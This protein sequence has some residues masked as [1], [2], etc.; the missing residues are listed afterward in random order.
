MGAPKGNKYA[1]GNEGGRPP[2]YATPDDLQKKI[3]EYFDG[4]CNKRKIFIG[5]GVI[6]IPVV[7][8][9]GLALFLGFNSRQSLSDYENKEEFTDIIKRGRLRI[10]M[11]YEEMLCEKSPAGAIFA[12]KNMG[13]HDKHESELTGKDGSALI[14]PA[15]VLTPD[16]SHEFLKELNGKC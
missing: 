1:I 8:I 4:G 6:E 2:M 7:T 10:E 13:W 9:C 14:P 16:E 3:D 12:L 15:R 5:D 11:N